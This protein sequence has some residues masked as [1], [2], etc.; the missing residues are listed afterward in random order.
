MVQHF[1]EAVQRVCVFPL[2]TAPEM[3]FRKVP[4]PARPLCMINKDSVPT[5]EK[6]KDC[7]SRSAEVL[8]E[9]ERVNG[10]VNPEAVTLY[11]SS[12]LP[13]ATL[14]FWQ[15]GQAPAGGSACLAKRVQTP[16][17]KLRE[18]KMRALDFSRL[19]RRVS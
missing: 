5:T 9:T 6:R 10:M 15:R 3:K 19:G 8:G 4:N 14:L 7:G 13:N 18:I 12:L 16:S 11:K 1:V 17:A 2:I